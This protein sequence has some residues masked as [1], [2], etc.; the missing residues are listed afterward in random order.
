MNTIILCILA[1]N[2]YFLKPNSKHEK[3]IDYLPRIHGLHR[4]NC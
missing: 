3:N 4:K 1:K 2:Y